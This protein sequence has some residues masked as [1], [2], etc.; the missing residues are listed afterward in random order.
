MSLLEHV[1]HQKQIL[2]DLKAAKEEVGSLSF[3]LANAEKQVTSLSDKQVELKDLKVQMAADTGEVPRLIN[4]LHDAR[5]DQKLLTDELDSLKERF[6]KVKNERAKDRARANL[7]IDKFDEQQGDKKKLEE[8]CQVI[9]N[10][11]DVIS[12]DNKALRENLE[13][14]TGSA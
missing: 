4:E 10:K 11:F 9:Q 12:A 2:D 14:L 5:I 8:Q 13:K 1:V 6:Q 3:R 7:H